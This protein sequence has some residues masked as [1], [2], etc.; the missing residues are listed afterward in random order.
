NREAVGKAAAW[1]RAFGDQQ[2]VP[3]AVLSGVFKLRN[4]KQ[5]QKSGLTLFWAHKLDKLIEWINSTKS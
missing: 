5:A 2:V 3:A 4:L 1:R